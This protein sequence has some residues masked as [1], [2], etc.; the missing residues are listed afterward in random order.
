MVDIQAHQFLCAHSR[1]VEQPEQAVIALPQ[2]RLAVDLGEDLLHF[3]PFQVFGHRLGVAFEWDRQNRLAVG[4]IAWFHLGD[5]LKEGM[6]GCQAIIP[7]RYCIVPFVLQIIQKAAH[8][9][10]SEFSQGEVGARFTVLPG[11]KLQQQ[12]PSVA[13]GQHRMRAESPV[14]DQMLLE[15][16]PQQCAKIS[17][18]HWL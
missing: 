5:V 2:R 6:N 9:I 16:V 7:G 1:V 14:C 18:F 4:Q 11:G 13:V 3:L 8:G 15:E 10:G 17:G 12:F